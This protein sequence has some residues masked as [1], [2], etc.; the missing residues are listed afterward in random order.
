MML[1]SLALNSFVPVDSMAFINEPL[2]VEGLALGNAEGYGVGSFGVV[3][4]PSDAC[5]LGFSNDS[6]IT[7]RQILG[8]EAD[9]FFKGAREI[10][11]DDL[12]PNE[13]EDMANAW[14][15]AFDDMNPNDLLNLTT[16]QLQDAKAFQTQVSRIIEKQ[17]EKLGK[18][19]G[20]EI[21]F[22]VTYNYIDNK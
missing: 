18:K 5:V 4:A 8:N 11:F 10:G 6:Y 12:S 20:S 22:D 9:D 21:T 7:G 17:A 3:V 2:Q 15:T 14:K 13:A 1:F 16:K 19:Y